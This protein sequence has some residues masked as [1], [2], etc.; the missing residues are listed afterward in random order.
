MSKIVSNPSA[1]RNEKLA[2][3]AKV[4]GRSEDRKKV[5]LAMHRGKQKIK[6]VSDICNITKLGRIR[7]LQ[8][9]KKL[10]AEDI[11]EQ[12]PN[13][14]K[15]ETAYRKSDFYSHNKNR[16]ISLV[17]SKKKLH[18]FPTRTNPTIQVPIKI[19]TSTRVR[20]LSLDVKLVTIDDIKSFSKVKQFRRISK[21]SLVYENKIK[22]GL[23]AIL[24]EKGRFKDWGGETSDLFTS[25]IILKNKRT[26]AAFAL[27]GRGTKGALT[28]GKMGKN[29]DQIQRLFKC[30]AEIFLVQYYGQIAESVLDQMESLAAAKSAKENKRIYY[31][32]IDGTDTTRL[33]K[34]YK[35]AFDGR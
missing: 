29:G 20:N 25:R 30:P 22:K 27:K 28:P 31:G 11:I 5:F 35:R 18:A 14:V 1:D 34:A 8:E 10:H 17:S 12:L 19:T 16:I 32:I 24:G 26:T 4:I 6:K 15:G 7:V 33:I 2:N 9:A 13:K 23:K 21:T 3:A